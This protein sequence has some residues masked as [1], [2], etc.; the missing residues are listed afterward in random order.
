MATTE[1]ND[2]YTA[3]TDITEQIV[4]FD[5]K[6]NQYKVLESYDLNRYFNKS[7]VDN[8]KLALFLA[9]DERNCRW[10]MKVGEVHKMIEQAKY[11]EESNEWIVK[12]Y[13]TTNWN[14][15]TEYQMKQIRAGKYKAVRITLSIQVLKTELVKDAFD[16]GEIFNAWVKHA[17]P[18]WK[19]IL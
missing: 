1:K 6:T 12:H 11:N 2:F 8:P 10:K 19:D 7:F 13:L 9:L 3:V 16:P 14:E 17:S 5:P 15:P 18:Y 4:K